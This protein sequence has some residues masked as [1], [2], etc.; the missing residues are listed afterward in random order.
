MN[1]V[2]F[3]CI[4]KSFPSTLDLNYAATHVT[5]ANENLTK[6]LIM[7]FTVNPCDNS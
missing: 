3:I 4:S 1:N 6:L 7:S 5:I 2:R